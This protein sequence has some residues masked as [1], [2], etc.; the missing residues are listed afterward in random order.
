MN[1][2]SLKN[3]L[4]IGGI[5]VVLLLALT[6]TIIGGNRAAN[7][8]A[9]AS[10]CQAQKIT[11]AQVTPNSAVISWETTDASQGR[12][13]YGTNPAGLT[14]TAPEGTSGKTHNVPLTLL[15]PNT[16]YYY[17]VTIGDT[18]CDSSGQKC[19]SNCVPWSFTTGSMTPIPQATPTLVPTLTLAP[20]GSNVATPS[21]IAPTSTLSSFCTQ[22]QLNI[23]KSSQDATTWATVKQYDIDNNGVINGLDVVKCQ[24]SGK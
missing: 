18:R 1:L 8:F 24:K 15:T 7:Y 9:K 21:S 11:T 13:E 14:F 12:V 16:V 2:A 19:E 10:S 17:L 4:K 5:L 23:G 22:V 20:S 6:V 3:S